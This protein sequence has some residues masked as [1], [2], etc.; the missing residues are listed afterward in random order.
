MEC[1][2]ERMRQIAAGL[3]VDGGDGGLDGEGRGEETETH[4]PGK[5]SLQR[6]LECQTVSL[7]SDLDR[8]VS[9]FAQVQRDLDESRKEAVDSLIVMLRRRIT[10]YWPHSTLEVFGS[11]SIGFQSAASD[12][13]LV[14]C[15]SDQFIDQGLLRI[16][17]V[18]PLL[19]ALAVYLGRE[20]TDAIQ[21]KKVLYHTRVP[22]IKAEATLVTNSSRTFIVSVDISIDSPV[23]SGMATTE[24]VRVL[25]SAFPVLHPASLVLKTFLKAKGVCDPYSGGLSSYGIVLLLLLLLIR[26]HWSREFESVSAH[27]HDS[28]KSDCEGQVR[29]AAG[30]ARDVITDFGYGVVRSR[31]PV[32]PRE[33]HITAST[34][35]TPSMFKGTESE[36]RG[37]ANDGCR[38]TSAE[39]RHTFGNVDLQKSFGRRVALKLL[40]EPDGEDSVACERLLR[41]RL[42]DSSPAVGSLVV[43]FLEFYGDDGVLWKHGFSLRDGGFRFDV[44]EGSQGSP[45][46]PQFSHPLVIEDP[47]NMKNNVGENCFNA[48]AV[49]SVLVEAQRSF[50]R[51]VVR[52]NAS[53]S[54]SP[55]LSVKA[56]PADS[57]LSEGERTTGQLVL[58][59]EVM[60]I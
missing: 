20:G 33:H 34:S 6:L 56:G 26:Q 16:R 17:G 54:T 55:C 32:S 47:V 53:P 24:L 9:Y 39:N 30:A 40:G 51:A 60:F 12:I 22:L 21:I 45:L 25:S 57:T 8:E 49:Q 50:K 31:P 42:S 5:T 44:L 48:F 13:D 11:H 59:G 38:L 14:V 3:G 37:D 4:R 19:Q 18:L 36:D 10:Q 43:Q 29:T 35:S 1:E 7:L 15:L 41:P 28:S 2:R 46:H 23:H 52:H 58:L 27:E